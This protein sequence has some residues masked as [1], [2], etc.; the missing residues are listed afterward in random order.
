[1]LYLRLHGGSYVQKTHHAL[2]RMRC[3][4]SV[5]EPTL[6]NYRYAWNGTY[7]FDWYTRHACPVSVRATPP[8]TP[9]NDKS[10]T[11]GDNEQPPK[12]NDDGGQEFAEPTPATS[13]AWTKVVWFFAAQVFCPPSMPISLIFSIDSPQLV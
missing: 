3:D 6:P 8:P 7:W 13:R 9:D 12:D 11:G 10:K 2:F 1:M 5:Q 4:E